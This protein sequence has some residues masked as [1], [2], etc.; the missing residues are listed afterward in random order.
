MKTLYIAR[1][2]KS[3]WSNPMLKDFERPLNTRGK[4]NTLKMGKLLKKMKEFPELIISSPA[5]RAISTARR[6]SKFL[7]YNK[8]KIVQEK[9]LYMAG[10]DDFINTISTVKNKISKLMVVSH[11]PGVTEFTD[12]KCN[13]NI[14]NI[15]TCSVV[16]IDFDM[17]KWS[18]IE[19]TTGKI[20]FFE[21]PKKHE[22]TETI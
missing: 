12:I 13:E 3:S 2:A 19:S 14:S 15:P 17:K 8:K 18:D 11:N 1:H 6:L 10:I 4:E 20:I 16:R 21:Y 7:N 9:M 5:K 22:G